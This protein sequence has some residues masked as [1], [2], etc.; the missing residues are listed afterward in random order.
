MESYR[1]FAPTII[2]AF[3]ATFLIYMAHDNVFSD[4]R[5]AEFEAFLRGFGFPVVPLSARASVYAQF[6]AGILFAVGLFVRVASAA[7]VFNFVVALAVVHTRQPFQ[8]ALAPSAMLASA[9]SLLLTG[10]GAL[11]LDRWLALRRHHRTGGGGAPRR[12]GEALPGRAAKAAGRRDTPS[13]S[14]RRA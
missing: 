2:R 8:A 4:V 14:S 9:L 7:M 10:A 3:A 6:T 1:D 12:W 13:A 5:M 11:S